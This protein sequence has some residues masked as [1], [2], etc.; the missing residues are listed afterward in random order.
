MS[1]S[2]MPKLIEHR[3]DTLNGHYPS[4]TYYR[5]VVDALNHL[6]AY[7]HKQ[8]YSSSALLGDNTIGAAGANTIARFKFRSG[9]GAKYVRIILVL[10]KDITGGVATDPTVSVVIGA[11]IN[12]SG[13][14]SWGQS[15]TATTDAPSDWRIVND[16]LPIDPDAD[17]GCEVKTTDYAR[18]LAVAVY[19]LGEPTIS[20]AVD[21]YS[22]ESFGA[23]SP[24]YDAPQAR[25]LEG[26]SNIWRH[27]G[28]TVC[29]WGLRDG[30]ARTRSSATAVNLVD[31]STTGAPTAATPGWTLDL[32]YRATEGRAT[33]PVE[34]AAYGAMSAGS[35]VSGTV[36]LVDS[37]G[38]TVATV[39]IN[40]NTAGWFTTTA[41]LPAT[42]AKY[43][44]K[45]AGDGVNTI[46]V[47]AV[48]LNEW[49]A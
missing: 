4:A 9:H 45:F 47:Y 46:S 7:R 30:A 23:D 16:V 10:G 41:L 11:S 35:G 5:R 21:Y 37:G 40:S 25:I 6:T 22:G 18:V 20:E 43:D 39:T 12:T 28:G 24:I 38:T 42:A 48:S 27:N 36:L 49:E 15:P 17:Y 34:I 29:H 26:L 44:L 31:N 2:T 19:E 3:R 32:T 13:P 1:L 14:H 8:V 33:V